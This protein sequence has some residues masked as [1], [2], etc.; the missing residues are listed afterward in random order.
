VKSEPE[1]PKG[2]LGRFLAGFRSRDS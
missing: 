1:A 2:L